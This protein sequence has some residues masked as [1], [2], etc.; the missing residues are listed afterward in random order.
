[1]KT[2]ILCGGMGYR[3]QEETEFKPKP[4]VLV[5]DKPILWHIMKTYSHH[6]H[7]QF[8][9]TLGYKGRMIKEHFINQRIYSQNFTHNVKTGE[10]IY[11]DD[12]KDEFIIT[13][14]ETGQTSPTGKR[15]LLAKQYITEEEFMVTYG[16]GVADI[17]INELIEFHRRHGK[18]GTI[19]GVHPHS[20]YGL[21]SI[22]E[23]T[24]LAKNFRQ[25]PLMNEYTNGGFMVFNRK[26]FKYFDEGEMENGLKRL[27]KKGQLA[28]Y[29]HDGFWKA[30][31]TFREMIDL[32]KLWE[33][34]KPWAVWEKDKDKIKNYDEKLK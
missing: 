19:T 9:L 15:L 17:N 22:D 5:G 14:A 13:F 29:K 26:A 20:K 30:M 34:K 28:V 33:A 21:I 6:G 8:V 2:I 3:L 4:M 31:D 1:M 16:D 27:A 10:V 25:K 7:N 24:S 23:K 18:I 32:N 11:H 12:I